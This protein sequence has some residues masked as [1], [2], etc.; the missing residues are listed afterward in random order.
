MMITA[1][2]RR[3]DANRTLR[4]AL[5]LAQAAPPARR[6]TGNRNESAI[7]PLERDGVG[8]GAHFTAD[9]T[10]QSPP[11]RAQRSVDQGNRSPRLAR[12]IERTNGRGCRIIRRPGR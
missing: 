6:R 3:D 12:A 10:R 7:A 11:R 1:I 5:L 8:H 4:R 2:L 9:A